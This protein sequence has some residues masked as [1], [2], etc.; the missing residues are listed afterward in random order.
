MYCVCNYGTYYMYT[1]GDQMLML[2][3]KS[4]P[5]HTNVACLLAA[6]GIGILTL[7]Y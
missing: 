5:I 1:C 2:Y 3:F 6:V 7:R 4:V